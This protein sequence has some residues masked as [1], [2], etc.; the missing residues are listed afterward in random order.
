M[1]DLARGDVKLDI[2]LERCGDRRVGNWLP[3]RYKAFHLGTG[4]H[5][6]QCTNSEK[7]F[8]AKPVSWFPLQPAPP[9]RYRALLCIFS[10]ADPGFTVPSFEIQ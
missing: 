3:A 6:A 7:W 10:F 9:I 8:F 5:L 2:A 1:D 4:S